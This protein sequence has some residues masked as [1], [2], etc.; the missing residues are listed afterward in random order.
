MA[1]TK[2]IIFI[3]L[4]GLAL[5]RLGYFLIAIRSAEYF[6]DQFELDDQGCVLAGQ[7]IGMIGSEDMT[8]GKHD[9]L[10]ITSGDLEKTFGYGAAAANTGSIFMMNLKD[11]MPKDPRKV[12]LVKANIHSSP[13]TRKGFRFQP[14]GMDISNKTD[15][16]YVVNHNHGYSSVIVFDIMYNQECLKELDCPLEDLASLHFKT[17][18]RSNLFPLMALN[19]VVEASSN[20]FYVT[21]WLPYAYPKRYYIPSTITCRNFRTKNVIQQ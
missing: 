15:R 21:Q 7:K 11:D 12:Q 4:F 13:F 6:K 18:I 9:I 14:H 5:A 10:F 8:L 1:G 19:D 16:L 3:A 20:E 2:T 17:E